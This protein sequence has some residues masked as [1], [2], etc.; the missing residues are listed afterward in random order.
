MKKSQKYQKFSLF[1]QVPVIAR[2]SVRIVFSRDSSAHK[3]SGG[4][5]GK[6]P[7]PKNSD[8]Q[9]G[10]SSTSVD[11]DDPSRPVRVTESPE[12]ATSR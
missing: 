11:N 3:E 7:P 1:Y 6:F 9:S 2:Q 12:S 8:N 10:S 5:N 4:T